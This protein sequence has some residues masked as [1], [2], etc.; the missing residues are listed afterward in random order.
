[1]CSSSM[2]LSRQPDCAGAPAANTCCGN[3]IFQHTGCHS[4]VCI[5]L[6]VHPRDLLD[7]V[8]AANLTLLQ[9]GLGS[10]LRIQQAKGLQQ[11]QF[12]RSPLS[13]SRHMLQCHFEGQCALSVHISVSEQ[14]SKASDRWL[15][16]GRGM[17]NEPASGH[18]IYRVKAGYSRALCMHTKRLNAFK[19]I[20][21]APSRQECL[22]VRKPT[23]HPT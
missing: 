16:V 3:S 13:P 21:H 8:A 17:G 12:R 20:H 19:G 1:M 9:V 11:Q 5:A 7:G 2:L 10:C 6:T 4:T 14:K 23:R 22:P 18:S 15:T